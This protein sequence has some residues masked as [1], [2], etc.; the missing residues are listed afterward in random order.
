MIWVEHKEAVERY[1]QKRCILMATSGLYSTLVEEKEGN[2]FP[3]NIYAL[4]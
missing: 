1:Q 2:V 4:L 3:Q